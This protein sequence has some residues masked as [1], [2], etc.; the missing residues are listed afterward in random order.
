MCLEAGQYQ[1]MIYDNGGDGICCS[2]GE[3][4]YNVISSD[5][6]IAQGGEFEYNETVIFNLPIESLEEP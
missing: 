5:R 6:I 2:Y 1:F 3:G 4:G